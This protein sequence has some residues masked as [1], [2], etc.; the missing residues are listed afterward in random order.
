MEFDNKAVGQTIRN[1]RE[2]KNLSQD[3]LSGLAGIARSHL[4]MIETGTKQANF[5]TI[6]RIALAL[7]MRPSEL[8]A[9]IE[10]TAQKQSASAGRL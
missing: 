5:Q 6:W 4:S 10:E 8:V 7:E 9:R 3:V 1:L 2:S